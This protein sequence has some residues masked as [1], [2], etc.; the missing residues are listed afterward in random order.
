MADFVF[1]PRCGS[2]IAEESVKAAET[3]YKSARNANFPA[4]FITTD[5]FEV[6]RDRS[7]INYPRTRVCL[8]ADESVR[9]VVQIR[10]SEHL[11]P[12]LWFDLVNCQFSLHYSFSSE[13]RAMTYVMAWCS[14]LAYTEIHT[15]PCVQNAD[16]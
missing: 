16:Y 4:Y 10:L 7:S 6:P 9:L 5:C 11:D 12:S 2:D 14:R 1:R 15:S 13:S 3:R 8:G